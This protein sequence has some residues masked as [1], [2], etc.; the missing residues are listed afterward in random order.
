MAL[1]VVDPIESKLGLLAEAIGRVEV[2][3][4]GVGASAGRILAQ[5]I[6]NFRDS[7]ALD[8][9]AM[10]GYAFCWDDIVES[11]SSGGPLR[12][13]VRR[14]AAAGASLLRM[15]RGEA[16]RIFTGG[17]V[18]EGAS[19]VIPREVCQEGPDEVQISFPVK[20]LKE[21]WNIR[22][23]GENARLGSVA[24][25]RGVLI[26]GPRL[27]SI[28]STIAQGSVEVYRKVRVRVLNTGNELLNVGEPIEP[29]QIRDSNGPFLE[30]MLSRCGWVQWDRRTVRD[31]R[32][33][34]HEAV[35]QAM[36]EVDAVLITGGVSM[37]DTDHVPGA[38]SASGGKILFH[39]L[40][41]RPGAPIL[42]A[43]S[44][45]GQL[46]MGLPG[47]PMS[48][49]VT[50]R[51]FA[52]PLLRR[53][54]GFALGGEWERGSAGVRGTLKVGDGK[55]LHLHWYRLVQLDSEGYL[56]LVGHQGSG[57]VVALGRSVGFI[58]VPA[59]QA[60]EG[61]FRYF[62]WDSVA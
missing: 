48:V 35:A 15:E 46:V 8:V 20:G 16:I 43:T 38:V 44:Q 31:D 27:S 7:P 39:R 3:T 10:D 9:S 19:V 23:R 56:E 25:Q 30:G 52:W 54:G 51:R 62:G 4:V 29:W 26:D 61:A 6:L 5:E 40:P 17:V 33:E 60:T 21:G 18:P 2:E 59:G 55:S 13:E 41:I 14:V 34:V 22:R 42:G 37:G 49:A 57:D 1:N 32:S 45:R 11:E 12:L 58:E 24:L 50:F 36:R 28:V 47:N 53:L